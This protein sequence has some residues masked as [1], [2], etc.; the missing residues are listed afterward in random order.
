[1]NDYYGMYPNRPFEN[2]KPSRLD[3]SL[4][5]KRDVSLLLKGI[6]GDL[7]YFNLSHIR[8]HEGKRL[9]FFRLSCYGVSN[10]FS[11]RFLLR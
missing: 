4:G 11:V 1:M 6:L 7:G 3:F 8:V 10:I 9:S 2:K 5:M